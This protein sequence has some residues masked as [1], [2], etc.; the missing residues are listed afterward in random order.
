MK[1]LRTNL[2]LLASTIIFFGVIYPL[3][4]WSIGLIFPNQANGF[5]ISQNG[6]VIGY[7]NIGQN[8]TEAKYFWDRPSA[9]NYN[10]INAGPTNMGPTNPVF[11]STVE[12]RVDTFLVQNPG[13]KKSEIPS[14]LVT[15]SA[16]GID[17]DIS[18]QGAL[19]QIPR[20]A[21]ARGISQH[22]L[23][24]L[25]EENIGKPLLGLF[26]PERVNVLK[27]NLALDNLTKKD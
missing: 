9:C 24:K 17:P 19:I 16:S 10:P 8:F 22:D 13:I 11:L 21:K 26:G 5:P 1:T 23:Q 2:V 3:F 27:L 14:D 25:V 6:K 20:V 4:V 12:Q 18:V 15:A 7:K